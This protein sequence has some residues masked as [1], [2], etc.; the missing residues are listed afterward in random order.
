M[1]HGS[2][3]FQVAL[4]TLR[5]H[6]QLA[7][8]QRGLWPLCTSDENPGRTGAH[9]FCRF[10]HRV[11]Q[12]L[13]QSHAALLFGSGAG[14]CNRRLTIFLVVIIKILANIM[15]GSSNSEGYFLANSP[16]YH[17]AN[18]SYLSAPSMKAALAHN[19]APAYAFADVS[20][21]ETTYAWCGFS[22]DSLGL[23][24]CEDA[25][26]ALGSDKCQSI[27]FTDNGCCIP[28]VPCAKSDHI[29][30]TTHLGK[31]M[32]TYNIATPTN[33]PQTNTSSSALFSTPSTSDNSV[34]IA[35]HSISRSYVWIA[36]ALSIALI[37]FA[38]IAPSRK[39]F[40]DGTRLVNG[41]IGSRG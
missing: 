15:I 17:C 30:T 37:L 33:P 4:T 5:S 34:I 38:L 36:I 18:A 7:T 9:V 29:Q 24:Q 13:L 41:Q 14:Y 31:Q 2:L 32:R 3:G 19:P 22:T 21:T 6:D 8:I 16:A 23:T 39:S 11:T 12:T 25:C 20:L 26:D 28:F 35:G 10:G 40:A 1:P 27:S